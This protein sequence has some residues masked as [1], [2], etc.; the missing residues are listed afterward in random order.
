VVN[1]VFVFSASRYVL[2]GRSAGKSGKGTS[3]S[4]TVKLIQQSAFS[5]DASFQVVPPKVSKASQEIYRQ[6]VERGKSGASEPSLTDLMKYQKYA[7]DSIL[8]HCGW[9]D[10]L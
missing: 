2:I 5:L 6:Y 7:S 1:Q 4:K 8:Q 3:I 10:P 9:D